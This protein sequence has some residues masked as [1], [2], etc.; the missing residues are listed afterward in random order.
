MTLP[1]PLPVSAFYAES[2]LKKIYVEGYVYTQSRFLGLSLG[3]HNIGK[4][5]WGQWVGQWEQSR[6]ALLCSG[7]H[8]SLL[9]SHLPAPPFS[10]PAL[11]FPSL[12][13]PCP[14]PLSLCPSPLS[15]C[16]SPVH[17]HLLE[18]GEEYSVSLPSAYARSIL[19]VPW[20]ELGGKCLLECKQTGYYANIEFHCKPFYGGRRH[21]VTAD[22]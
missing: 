3:V 22:L 13:L 21:R 20:M 1:R 12:T 17:M 10:H 18:H 8:H 14:S 2:P 16:P 5:G 19:T 6:H 4:G 9:N 7:H 15:P 11:S